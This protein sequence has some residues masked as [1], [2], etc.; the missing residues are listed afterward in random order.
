MKNEIRAEIDAGSITVTIPKQIAEKKSEAELIAIA[1]AA[2][3][4]A[5][6][7]KVVADAI[8]E[9]IKNGSIFC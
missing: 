5:F 2:A 6:E 9:A 4:R 8:S 3:T 7:R 1:N